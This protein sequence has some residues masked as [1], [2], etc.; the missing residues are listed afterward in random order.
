MQTHTSLYAKPRILNALKAINAIVPDQKAHVA[1]YCL[2]GTL[3][4]IAAATLAR[5]SK[6]SLKSL[7]LFT[8]QVDFEEAGE[9]LMFTDESQLAWLEDTMWEKGYLDSQHC[10]LTD[11][12]VPDN[13]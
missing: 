9:L 1:G 3:A 12:R 8:A 13:W 10:A 2:G 4:A 7:T 6:N 11:I 5:D